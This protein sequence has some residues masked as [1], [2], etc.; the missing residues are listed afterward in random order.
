MCG[1][2]TALSMEELTEVIRSVEEELA[3]HAREDR[4]DQ[5]SPWDEEAADLGLG[6]AARSQI[7]PATTATGT[8][9]TPGS[10]AA[11]VVPGAAWA[12]D[13]GKCCGSGCSKCRW[14]RNPLILKPM[15]MTW[16]YEVSWQKGRVFNTRIEHAGDPGSMWAES[17][18]RRRCIVPARAFFEPHQHESIIS[19]RTGKAIKRQYV[20]EP[21][22]NAA[23]RWLLLAG[24]FSGD[25]FSV[26]TTEPNSIV[27]PLH[28]RMPLVLEPADVATWLSPR[29]ADLADRSHVQLSARP[30]I[31][32]ATSIQQLTLF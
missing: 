32:N 23:A 19:P 18:E 25:C 3:A 2:F 30:E 20:F 8:M 6:P 12:Q 24:V 9:V 16:G 17:L 21:G 13:Q 22:P 11:I 5:S 14:T 7:Q 28:N 31:E 4:G 27:A 1:R 10:S 15:E 26:V 29:F